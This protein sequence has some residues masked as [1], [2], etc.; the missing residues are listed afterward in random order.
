MEQTIVNIRMD[1]SKKAQLDTVADLMGITT[2]GLIN[3]FINR[4]VFEKK[5]PFPLEVPVNT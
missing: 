4:V 1:K 5:L 2:S 3:I